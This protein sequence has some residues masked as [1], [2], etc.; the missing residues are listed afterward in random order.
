MGPAQSLDEPPH[1]GIAGRKAVLV[2]QILEDPRADSGILEGNPVHEES[3]WIGRRAGCDFIVNVVLDD[4]RRPLKFVAGDMEAAFLQGVDFVRHVRQQGLGLRLIS[5]N[6]TDT[7]ATLAGKLNRVG[8]DFGIEEI[9]T[10]TA[11]A[12]KRLRVLNVERCLFLGTPAL[13]GIFADDPEIVMA[14]RRYGFISGA[15]QE[16]IMSS[17]ERRHDISDTIDAAVTNRVLGISW[18]QY[19]SE[20]W[21]R[22]LLVGVVLPWFVLAGRAFFPAGDWFHLFLQGG[23]GAIAGCMAIVLLGMKYQERQRFV[24]GPLTQIRQQLAANRFMK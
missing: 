19:V 7:V 20:V 17:V 18:R 12:V 9:R 3:T 6:T 8:F 23:L 10:C 1:T 13:Q 16:T 5:N 24:Y 21:L 4:H 14:D 22:P 2:A 11:T 15:C